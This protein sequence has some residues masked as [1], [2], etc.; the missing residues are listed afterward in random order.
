[1]KVKRFFRPK[2]LLLVALCFFFVLA[3]AS[4][5]KESSST[6]SRRN[7]KMIY[8]WGDLTPED[9]KSLNPQEFELVKKALEANS[10]PPLSPQEQST[11]LFE[12]VGKFVANLWPQAPDYNKISAGQ[13][14]GLVGYPA[15]WI[16]TLLNS[17]TTVTPK[18]ML[19]SISPKIEDSFA[20]IIQENTTPFKALPLGTT[21][22]QVISKVVTFWTGFRNI[23]YALL[24]LVLVIF[25]FMIMLRQN[26]EPRVTMTIT[27][28]LPRVAVSLVLITFSFAISGLIIDVGRLT[29]SVL[30]NSFPELDNKNYNIYSML[31][32]FGQMGIMQTFKPM[33]EFDY[34]FRFSE[35]T[36]D[37]RYP[38]WRCDYHPD[39]LTEGGERFDCK[40]TKPD[41]SGSLDC[42]AFYCS[43]GTI[44]SYTCALCFARDLFKID[45]GPPIN[46]HSPGWTLCLPMGKNIGDPFIRGDE[47]DQPPA[48]C[49]YG[50]QTTDCTPDGP[51]L[52][53]GRPG[54]RCCNFQGNPMTCPTCEGLANCSTSRPFPEPFPRSFI[55]KI[56]MWLNQA[57]IFLVG[58]LI[59]LLLLLTLIQTVFALL[60]KLI[61]CFALWFILAVVSPFV[62]MWGTIPGQEE[63]I[64]SWLKHFLANVLAFPV[65]NFVIGMAAVFAD[66]IKASV[67]GATSYP[68]LL[69]LGGAHKQMLLLIPYGMVLLTPQI[70]D[71]LANIIGAKSMGGKG[72]IELGKNVK[73]LPIIGGLV[74]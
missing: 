31:F 46:W 9:M 36:K 40:R 54:N 39:C 71:I 22:L 21:E 69:F 34:V 56:E 1:M 8:N 20:Q 65:V 74:G 29:D 62:F 10:Q 2:I 24:T 15:I 60:F 55:N 41:A 35:K 67:P 64:S 11:L 4:Q 73:R 27:N 30:K 42:E 14:P 17:D 53:A 6:S 23:A 52:V 50:C 68:S 5:A 51:L 18:Q 19:A 48:G 12:S 25:G 57:L 28:A 63:T 3:P 45:I 43:L 26:L 13:S 37:E 33:K 66:A 70:P 61:T 38:D 16:T 58:L 44:K 49:E 32:Q 47:V 59:N 7:V 72:G